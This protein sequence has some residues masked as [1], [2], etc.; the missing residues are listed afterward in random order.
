MLALCRGAEE[1]RSEG[2]REERSWL[3]SLQTL[4]CSSWR[5][6]RTGRLRALGRFIAGGGFG[7]SGLQPKGNE[8]ANAQGASSKQLSHASKRQARLVWRGAPRRARG[9]ALVALAA[10]RSKRRQGLLGWPMPARRVRRYVGARRGACACHAACGAA[11]VL[12]ARPAA[13]GA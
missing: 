13:G 9:A 6:W 1:E 8:Q 10:L 12:Q 3:T 5:L 11:S 4:A 7:A 2:R